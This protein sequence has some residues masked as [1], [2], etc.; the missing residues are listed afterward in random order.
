MEDTLYLL[1][2]KYLNYRQRSEKEIKDYLQKKL[3][4]RHSE[5]DSDSQNIIFLVIAR[6]KK[7][8]FL[9][10]EEFAKMWIR[11]RKS[12][13]PKGERLIRLEL[14]QKGITKEI[15]DSVFEN[16][17]DQKSD[18]E[19]AKELLEK[20]RKKFEP[21]GRQE[22]FNKA[23]AFLARRGFD[24]DVIKKVIDQIFEK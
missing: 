14:K 16:N 13:R 2:L 17:E 18:L 19:L 5:L 7:Q 20:K 6:L 3:T 21:L 11:S 4:K 22:R 9:N 24:L 10:D 1:A 23:G 12:F 15:I 8:K